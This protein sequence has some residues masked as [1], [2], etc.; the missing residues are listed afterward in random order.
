[1]KKQATKIV[2]GMFL[3][4][5]LGIALVWAQAVRIPL[6]DMGSN[7]YLGF[8]GGLYPGAS[9]TVPADHDTAGLS[10]ASQV[11]PLDIN[12]N[13]ISNGKI[14]L[15]AVGMSNTAQE[16]CKLEGTTAC[17]A[18]SFMSQAAA[19]SR[20]NK[21]TLVIVNGAK[22]A[23]TATTWDSPLDANYDRVRDIVLPSMGVGEKQVQIIWLKV[24]NPFPTISLSSGASADA[25][26]LETS[27]GNILRALKIRYPNIKQVFASSR[28][29]GGYS[30]GRGATLNPEPYAYE[31]GFAFKWAIQAQIDQMSSGTIDAQA[32]DLNYTTV[33]PWIVWG[34]YLWADGTN[35]RSDGLVWL[36]TDFIID[37]VHPSDTGVQ[38]VGNMLLNFFLTSPYTTGWFLAGDVPTPFLSLS[39]SNP[40]T[41]TSQSSTITAS[42]SDIKSGIVISFTTSL[43]SL[44]PNNCTTDLAGKCS[45]SFQS[46]TTGT[47]TITVS[48]SGYTASSTTIKVSSTPSRTAS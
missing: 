13:P 11:Q 45:V 10:F 32:G 18:A 15:L 36:Q 47:A 43:G 31:S 30:T 14:V 25:Y 4:M 9:N 5:F 2:G 19:D 12:G 33:A 37:G 38:K 27:I 7:T 41:T 26:A 29:Y 8:T 20:V 23:Q 40:S 24:A 34:P 16:F 48:A 46:S 3:I 28:I 22:G 35:P 6:I 39:L 21:Q 44:T 42:T 17:H 1:M